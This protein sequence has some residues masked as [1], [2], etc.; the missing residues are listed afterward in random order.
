VTAASSLRAAVADG[1]GLR[2]RAWPL[3]LA[4]IVVVFY[5]VGYVLGRLVGVPSVIGSVA[6]DLIHLALFLFAARFFRGRFE[7]VAPPRPWWQ[8]TARAKLS[9]RLGVVAAIFVVLE[10]VVL[11]VHL[12]T[13]PQ[14]FALDLIDALNASIT[15]FLYLN[16][17]VRLDR[18]ERLA[19][20][21]RLVTP[22][23]LAFTGAILDVTGP[24]TRILVA[25]AKPSDA[26]SGAEAGLLRPSSDGRRIEVFFGGT[27]I[28][29]L[30]SLDA[31]HRD[32][33]VRAA[34][35]IRA[36]LIRTGDLL[37]AEV[38]LPGALPPLPLPDSS[39]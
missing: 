11:I 38:P 35:V 34:A 2:I 33:L 23:L 12:I 20:P 24:I 39:R 10:T 3:K 31:A 6:S 18:R 29:E 28:G 26:G 15:A 19:E 9:R 14:Q 7:E 21:A 16:C 36:P 27:R 8:V 25:E 37:W 22:Q 4:Y 32:A 13:D 5:G 30:Y 17:A 1:F